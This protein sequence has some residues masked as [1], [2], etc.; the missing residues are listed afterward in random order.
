MTVEH[1]VVWA[2][3]SVTNP[4]NDQEKILL[5]GDMLPGWVTEF[6]KFVLTTSG[7]VKVV[8][9]PDPDLVPEESL[10]EPVRLAEHPP[11][12]VPQV[13]YRSSKAELVDHGV[14]KGGSRTEL[15]ALNIKELQAKYLKA[16][17]S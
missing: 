14:A 13:N 6:T 3:C 8:D 15:E 7:A 5:K 10:P 12:P 17:Q 9:G 11:P 1:Q 16:E 4:E 2:K